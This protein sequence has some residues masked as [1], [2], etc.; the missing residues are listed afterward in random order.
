MESLRGCT[1]ALDTAPVIYFIERHPVYLDRL[2]PFFA[3]AGNK[4]FRL[5]TSMVTLLEVLVHAIRSQRVD[6]VQQYRSIL[7]HSDSLSTLPMSRS[8][9]E[10]AARLRAQLG[11][12][13]PDA[14]Q[15]ATALTA[16]ASYFLTNDKSLPS[17][18]GCSLLI[19]DEL[20]P[21]VLHH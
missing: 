7:M 21:S 20:P 14:I 4:E 1:V 12:K 13:T 8:V 11:L 3:A 18:A 5:V 15:F 6:L 17:I 2:R 9:A 16:G 10:E 19:V